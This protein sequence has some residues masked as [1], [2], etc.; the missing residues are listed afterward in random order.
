MPGQFTIRKATN[1]DHAS[2]AEVLFD[3]FMSLAANGY[4]DF[5]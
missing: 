2:L 1:D 3:G 4:L 5:A